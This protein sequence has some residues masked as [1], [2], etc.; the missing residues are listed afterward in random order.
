MP[1]I[2]HY[3]GVLPLHRSNNRP[4]AGQIGQSPERHELEIDP[5]TVLSRAVTQSTES[6]DQYFERDG[7]FIITS[8]CQDR[9]QPKR[10][11]DS[12]TLVRTNIESRSQTGIDL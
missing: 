9:F 11:A 5:D 7:V 2:K 8:H 6:I 10:F 1:S 3:T 12:K 4:G